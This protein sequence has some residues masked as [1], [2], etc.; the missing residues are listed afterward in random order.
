MPR[1][2]LLSGATRGTAPSIYPDRA[3]GGFFEGAEATF[4]IYCSNPLEDPEA[5]VHP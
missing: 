5:R 4:N 1:S 2:D 3:L